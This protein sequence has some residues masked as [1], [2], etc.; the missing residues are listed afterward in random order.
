MEL[1]RVM[2]SGK[3]DSKPVNYALIESFAIH[4]RALFHFFYDEKGQQD[5]VVAVD[6]FSAPS[7]WESVRPPC[8]E[9]LERSKKLSNKEAAHPA[10]ANQNVILEA[11]QWPFMPISLD[12]QKIVDVFINTVPKD[13]IGARWKLYPIANEPFANGLMPKMK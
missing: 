9:L 5:D 13:L 3:V 8:T 1:A 11:K 10:Y 6:F 4:V 2:G 12:I 7:D